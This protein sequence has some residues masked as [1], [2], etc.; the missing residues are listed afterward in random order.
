MGD[1]HSERMDKIEKKQE[2]I[3]GPPP[4]YAQQRP[5]GGASPLDPISVPDLDDPKEQEKLKYVVIPPKFKV[6]DFEKYDGTKCPVTHITMYCRRMAAYAHDDKLLIHCFQD[7]LTGAAAKWYVQL[8]RNRIHMWKDLARVFVAQYK[9]V[10]DMAPDCL[11][12][13][14]MEKKPTESFKEYAQRWRNVASQVQPPLIEKEITVMF[15]NTLR[16]P[17]YERLVGSAIKNFADM[18]ISGEMT[19]TA[20]KQRKIEGG[21]T[22]NTRKGGIFKRKEGEAQAITSRQHQ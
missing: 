7:S 1:E 16:A 2:E 22:A 14:N 11:F 18:V 10:T 3:M 15:V 9:H 6:P 17:Y 5:I 8:D 12:L 13:Q 20:I 19:N 4:T 21:D